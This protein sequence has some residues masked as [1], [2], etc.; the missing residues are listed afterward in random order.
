MATRMR[1]AVQNAGF[2][3]LLEIVTAICG[4][5]LPKLILSHYGSAYNG[6]TASITQFIGCV[7]ILKSGIGSVTRAALYKPLAQND[8]RGISEVVNATARFMRKVALVFVAG[9]LAFSALYPFIV[10]ED[11]EWF[12]S[13]SLVLILSI[14]TFAQYFFGLTYQM[15]LEADQRNYIISIVNIATTIVNTLLASFLI[16]RGLGIHAVKAASACVYVVPPVFYNLY[17]RRKYRIDKG[18]PP[19]YALIGE[20]W[21]AFGH[22]LANF[23]NLNTDIVIA[24]IFLGVKEV[25]VYTV[26]YLV[27]NA[28]K[29]AL[30]AIST[31]ITSAFGNMMAKREQD[32]LRRSFIEYETLIF[33]LSTTI[34]TIAMI[35]IVPFVNIYTSGVTDVVYN[36]PLFGYLVSVAIFFECVKLPYQQMVYASGQFKQTKMGAY[37]EAAINIVVSLILVNLLGLDGIVIGTIVALGFRTI[38][39]SRYVAGNIVVRSPG[40]VFKNLC[41]SLVT[42]ALSV[43][44][45]SRIPISP[46]GGYR[47]WILQALVCSAAVAAV[48]TAVGFL[49]FKGEMLSVMKRMASVFRRFGARLGRR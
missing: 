20:R 32:T 24:T 31:G 39:F 18:V 23:I 21:D 11:F 27:G 40:S 43:F 36:R 46:P 3:L 30:R 19:N 33:Y 8:Y 9:V 12:F 26:Y 22:Q 48:S 42:M 7:A 16:L 44:I 41:Y 4:F 29:K 25:S 47:E 28:I 10:I 45:R 15:V 49:F 34:L 6:I 13:F 35:M 17:V 5:I 37:S 2:E 1:R 38:H 14:A